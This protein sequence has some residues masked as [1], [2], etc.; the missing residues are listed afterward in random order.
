MHLYESTYLHATVHTKE[1]LS[2]EKVV[3]AWQNAA[4]AKLSSKRRI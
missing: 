4:W 1:T 2:E 3:Q